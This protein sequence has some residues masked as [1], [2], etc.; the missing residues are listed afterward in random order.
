MEN[1]L[2]SVQSLLVLGGGSDIARATARRLVQDR[3]RTVVLAGRDP[4]SMRPV[5]SELEAL[6]AETVETV[7]FDALDT[8]SHQGFVDD[9]FERHGDVDAVL[10]AFGVLGDQE[11]AEKDPR[12][13]LHVVETNYVGAV[14]VLVPIAQR[15]H[16]QGHGTLVVLSSVA[17]E[18]AR[19]SNFVYGSSKAGLDAFS[20]GLSY[21]LDGSGARVLIVRPGFV[22]TK[23][24][25]GRDPVPFSTDPETVAEAI[26]EGI[27]DG[28]EIVW[29]PGILRWIMSI[30]RHVPRAIFRRLPL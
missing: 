20:Q 17:G 14:S 25:A 9:V 8:A 19:R 29:V 26:Q 7:A 3:T 6:G 15:L 2:G 16:A 22:R 10:L 27:R 28:S 30:L 1:A 13:A 4:D 21:A 11:T 12:A 23:M 18:R 24:T 5:A